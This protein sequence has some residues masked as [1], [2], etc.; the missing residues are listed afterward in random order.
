MTD[1]TAYI[2]AAARAGELDYS[3]VRTSQDAVWAA[4][5][6]S[7]RAADEGLPLDERR[8]AHDFVANLDCDFS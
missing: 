4:N 3:E 2:Y 7:E 1:R 8:F 6:Y 5:G